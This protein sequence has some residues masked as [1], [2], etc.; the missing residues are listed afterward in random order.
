M[1][2]PRRWI[3]LPLVASA[4]C[5]ADGTITDPATPGPLPV[6]I[7]GVVRDSLSSDGIGAALVTTAIGTAFTDDAGRFEVLAPAGS[8]TVRVAHPQYVIK[9]TRG[10]ARSQATFGFAL[11]PLGPVVLG[12]TLRDGRAWLLVIDLQG[13]KTI[14]RRDSSGVHLGEGALAR[15]LPAHEFTWWALDSLTWLVDGPPATA[16]ELVSAEWRLFD[17]DG[18]LRPHRCGGQTVPLRDEPQDGGDTALVRAPELA[19]ARP[20][21]LLSRDRP[22]A[23]DGAARGGPRAP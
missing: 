4:A 18:N 14:V 3:L 16:A 12:C 15:W 2:F 7:G 23:R 22:P 1:P 5:T 8:T 21:A 17:T 13:R 9:Q 6:L 20:R 10:T 19:S 11:A